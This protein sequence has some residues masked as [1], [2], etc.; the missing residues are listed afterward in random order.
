MAIAIAYLNAKKFEKWF[1]GLGGR[2]Q[3]RVIKALRKLEAGQFAAPATF[4]DVKPLG[5]GLFEIRVHTD[6]GYR[7]YFFWDDNVAVIVAAGSKSHQ[8]SQI[9][10][11][12]RLKSAYE[13]KRNARTGD[14]PR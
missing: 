2:A 5:D 11:A 7:I 13:Q 9:N 6:A 12:R 3:A 10:A 4:G 1:G 14:G 8:Q